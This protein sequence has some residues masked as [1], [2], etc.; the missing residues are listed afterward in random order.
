MTTTRRRDWA[1][2]SLMPTF[3]TN[4]AASGCRDDDGTPALRV[5]SSGAEG[6]SQVDG[7]SGATI[8]C[9]RVQDIMRD[10]AEQISGGATMSTCSPWIQPQRR[11]GCGRCGKGFC[12]GKGLATFKDVMDQQ[13]GRRP[14]A[15]DLPRAGGHHTVGELAGDGRRDDLR[16]RGLDVHAVLAPPVRRRA[17]SG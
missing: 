17:A 7:I 1:R 12:D 2:R 5:V 9:D 6:R 3:W 4:S 16:L 11:E 13:S 8:T 14:D 15:G 10:L